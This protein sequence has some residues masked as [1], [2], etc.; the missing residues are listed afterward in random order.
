MADLTGCVSVVHVYFYRWIWWALAG[1]G[2]AQRLTPC[3]PL[4]GGTFCGY[5]NRMAAA[6]SKVVSLS[7]ALVSLALPPGSCSVACG[8]VLVGE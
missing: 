4:E 5:L 2:D 3:S 7:F 8:I 6:P 1:G